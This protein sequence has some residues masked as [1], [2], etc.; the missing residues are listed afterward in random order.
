MIRNYFKIALRSLVKNSVYSFINIAGLAVGLACSI[1]LLLWVTDELSFDKFHSN[2]NQIHQLHI[3]STYDGKIN[4]VGT[5]PFPAKDELKIKDS[6]I[7]NTVLVDNTSTHLLIFGDKRINQSGHVVSEEFLDIFHFEMLNGQPEIALDDP[8]SIVLTEATAKALFGDADPVGQTILVNNKYEVK[9]TGVLKNI[10]TNSS[11]QF[12]FLLPLNLLKNEEYIKEADGDW[13]DYSWQVFVELQPGVSKEEVETTIKN[14]LAEKGQTDM[15]REFFLHPMLRWRLHSSFE[16]G[17]ESEGMNNLNDLVHG[18]S[19]IAIFIS[20]MA[21]INFMN[22]ATARSESR[23]REVGIRK[24]IGSQRKELIFQFIG[25]SVLITAI[26]FF[27]A[28]VLV[29]L[30]LPLYNNM[31]GKT[32]FIN[33]SDSEFWLYSVGIILV[34]GFFAGSYPAFYLSSFEPAKVLKGKVQAGKNATPRQALVVLQFVFATGLMI[35]TLVISQQIQYTKARTLGYDQEN[36]I[37]VWNSDEI[38]KNYKIIKQELLNSGA[39]VSV[40]KS[41]SPVTEIFANNFLEWPGKPKDQNVIFS[42]IA[43]EYDYTKTLGIKMLEGRDFSEDFRGDTASIL[44][45]KAGAEVMGLKETIGT[46]V[47]FWG[48]RKATIVGVMDNVLMGSPSAQ[49]APS[50][51]LFIPQWASAITIRLER[52][53]DTE[54]ALK[55]VENIFRKLDPAHPFEYAFVDDQ[56]AKK[57]SLITMI[58]RIANLFTILAVIITSLGLF[59]LAAFTAE[60]R[61]KEIGI[62]KLMGASVQS[63]VSLITKEFSG[64]VMIAFIIAAPLSWWG[65]SHFLESYAYRIDFPWWVIAFSGAACLAFTLLIVST[66]ALKAA[67]SNPVESLRSE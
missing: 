27:L 49:V 18:F 67:M 50:F 25:E 24:T 33:Y 21:C 35:G 3:N 55:K 66:Q 4:K 63:L 62:R 34:T 37:T 59:G 7:K 31:V 14:I 23:A 47:T 51:V 43:T 30:S 60:Q 15:P 17:K 1:L 5:V 19:I 46:S 44:V 8:N 16:N 36:L 57:F 11:I 65:F 40:T 58:N 10:P 54:A 64:L 28:L 45:N 13:G 26:S 39:V 32:L 41:N 38:N 20:V 2:A 61:R 6:R 12:N 29:E 42:T 53:V 52:T 9:V 48:E 22:L 56:Y